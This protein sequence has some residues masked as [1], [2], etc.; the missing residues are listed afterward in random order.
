VSWRSPERRIGRHA[1]G[2]DLLQFAL[3]GVIVF[4]AA[5]MISARDGYDG[6]LPV[7]VRLITN[8]S[9][10]STLKPWNLAGLAAFAAG[11]S[12]AT[13]AAVTLGRFYSSSL[14]TRVDHQVVRH[15]VY[16]LVRHPIYLGVLVACM[17]IPLYA[18]SAGGFGVMSLLIPIVL[19]RIRLE[20]RLLIEQ[21]GESYRSYQ[22]T[23][24]MLVPFCRP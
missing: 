2:R 1:V 4:F 15:G 10:I 20:E 8:P 11:L 16:R 9:S 17:G 5:L 18:P 7:Y 3:P 22:R 23:T 14:V 6:L 21:L 19:N 12:F 13:V 24:P